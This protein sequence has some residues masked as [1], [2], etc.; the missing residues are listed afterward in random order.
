MATTCA[1][2]TSHGQKTCYRAPTSRPPGRLLHRQWRSGPRRYLRTNRICY[3][4]ASR[5]GSV[6][7]A[8]WSSP[9]ARQ[10]HNLKV[11]GS[12]PAPATNSH[13]RDTSGVESAPQIVIWRPCL[14]A[15][16][17]PLIVC[18]NVMIRFTRRIFL[19]VFKDYP[20]AREI[21]PAS[22]DHSTIEL[23]A[24]DGE[25]VQTRGL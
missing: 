16:Q 17:N 15:P 3:K 2:Q 1:H 23:S 9:V 21:S 14:S 18:K 8:G 6:G 20:S 5:F 25:K 11:V 4:I 7:D 10:A 13:V 24:I 12:N 19:G 22:I